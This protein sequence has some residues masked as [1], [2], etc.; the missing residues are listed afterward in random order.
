VYN[1]AV[2]VHRS[3]GLDVTCQVTMAA[4]QVREKFQADLLRP[5]LDFAEVW[6]RE[7]EIITFHDPLA[8]ATIFD[9][10]ICVFEKGIV[11][12]ELANEE[13]KGKTS[14]QQGGPD[15]PHEVALEVDRARFFEHYFSVFGQTTRR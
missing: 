9:D 4:Q 2:S 1:A 3:I 14:W 13:L 12:V 10:Q 7:R 6:F 8:A 15:A 11:A 5:V